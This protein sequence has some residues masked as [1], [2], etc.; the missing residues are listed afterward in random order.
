MAAW[1]RVIDLFRF[2]LRKDDRQ[3]AESYLEEA[4]L[5]L[6]NQMSYADQKHAV[7]VGRYL[8]SDKI[9]T[10]GADLKLLIKA[11]LLHDVG[12]VKGEI[13]WWNR[14]IVGVIRR[15][16]P[17]LR[18]KRA[19]RGEA[20]LGHALYVDLSHPDRGAYMAQSLGIDPTVVSLIKHH[21]DPLNEQASLELALLQ[22]ADAKS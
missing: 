12:K 18:Q 6:F 3:L 7:N 13:A 11:A 17:K 8:L 21:H 4:G 2:K 15:F 14:I 19:K 16:F 1:Q 9:D 20:G 10:T 5:F 22:I